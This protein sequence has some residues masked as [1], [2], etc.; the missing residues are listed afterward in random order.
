MGTFRRIGQS[1]RE[2][3]M[4]PTQINPVEGAELIATLP[5]LVLADLYV[6]DQ[7]NDKYNCVAW[8][9]GKTNEWYEPGDIV[10][11][12]EVYLKHG[13]YEVPVRSADAT[14]DL[15]GKSSHYI[16]HATKLYTGAVVTGM[17]AGL[18]ESKLAQGIRITHSRFGLE[19]R[20]GIYG[21]VVASFRKKTTD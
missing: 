9:L 6:T 16:T 1:I 21:S 4:P 20:G 17:P 14:V 15:M 5:N 8:T 13:F 11:M 3:D 19:D 10:N 7:Y 12:R 2:G 18:W